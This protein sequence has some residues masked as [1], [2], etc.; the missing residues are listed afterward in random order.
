MT[1]PRSEPA[2]AP[3][4]VATP[5]ELAFTTD[6][7]R[8]YWTNPNCGI[9]LVD[10]GRDSALVW[11]TPQG[12]ERRRWTEISAVNMLLASDGK[13]EVNQCRIDFNDGRS[14]TVSDAGANGQLD[15]TRTPVYRAFARALNARLA[16]APDGTIRF[17]AGMTEGHYRAMQILLGLLTVLFVVTPVVLVFIVRDWR[18]LGTLAAGAAFIWPFWRLTR[19]NAPRAYDPRH[20]PDELMQ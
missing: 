8:F 3:A 4:P 11:E 10:A 7:K 6:R 19:N 17:T 2:P 1:A 5:Y 12:E 20:P 13:Q 9:T 16:H 18:V 15:E 14:L